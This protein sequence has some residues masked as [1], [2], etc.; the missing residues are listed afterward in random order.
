MREMNKLYDVIKVEPKENGT[1]YLVF[2]NQEE[3]IFDMKPFLDEKP[4]NKLK[5]KVLFMQASVAYGTVVWPENID[6]A[7]ETLWSLSEKKKKSATM[8]QELRINN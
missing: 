7:P 3:R 6:I 1:L 4:F 2:E 8:N 5:Q